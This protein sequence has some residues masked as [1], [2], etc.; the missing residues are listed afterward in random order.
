VSIV[1][2][3]ERRAY[4][5]GLQIEVGSDYILR[6][7]D[8]VRITEHDPAS[9]LQVDI[10]GVADAGGTIAVF[11][12]IFLDLEGR[13]RSALIN[14]GA[15][16]PPARCCWHAPSGVFVCSNG[17]KPHELDIVRAAGRRVG[18]SA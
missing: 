11:A 2:R 18:R 7:G 1:E 4:R 12:G 5:F 8:R 15:A 13:A 17:S 14:N 9:A 16:K 3:S 6:N 10:N